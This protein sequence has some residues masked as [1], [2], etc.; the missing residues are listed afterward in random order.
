MRPRPRRVHNPGPVTI[1]RVVVFNFL[2]D[3]QGYECRGGNYTGLL[4][5]CPAISFMD[6]TVTM[7]DESGITI[8]Q[9]T[10][11]FPWDK[12]LFWQRNSKGACW[13]DH[14]PEDDND[15][16]TGNDRNAGVGKQDV[17]SN[18]GE[19]VSPARDC[20]A[21]PGNGSLAA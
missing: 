19:G 2:P 8:R 18:S 21:P 1:D 5:K 9:R 14:N 15:N 13:L 3:D 10:E 20:N 11:A 16:D 7:D 17:G 12:E 6:R 4:E